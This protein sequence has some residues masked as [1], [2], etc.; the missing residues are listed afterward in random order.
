MEINCRFCKEKCIKNGFQS[1]GRQRYKCSICKRKQQNSYLY[2]AC[3]PNVNNQIILFIKEGL[4]IRS[5]SRILKISTTT[6]LRR[7]III[8]KTI[9]RPIIKRD[10]IYEVDEMRTF[11]QRKSKLIWIV[12]ALERTSKNV[13]S[14]CVGKRT[15]KTL[16]AVIKT[17]ELSKAKKIYTDRLRNY[18]SLIPVGLHAVKPFGTNRIERNN[19]TLRTHLK[20]LNRRTICFSRSLLVLNSVLKI[21]FLG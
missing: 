12:Y 17:L 8:G 6:L 11:I 19:L 4:G 1:N 3:K 9:S 16:H 13:I 21:Y 20:R 7:I 18:K 10:K 2:N 14:F 15:N 5:T